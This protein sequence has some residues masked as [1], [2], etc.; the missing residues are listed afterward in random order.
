MIVKSVNQNGFSGSDSR[1][2][3]EYQRLE[4]EASDVSR[5]MQEFAAGVP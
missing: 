1:M 5:Q 3:A 2:N 4:A